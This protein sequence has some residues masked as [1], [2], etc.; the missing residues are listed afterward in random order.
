V[1]T[2]HTVFGTNNEDNWLSPSTLNDFDTVNM[3][4]HM[5]IEDLLERCFI[6]ALRVSVL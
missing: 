6:I 2:A 1:P 5:K 3:R 4:R